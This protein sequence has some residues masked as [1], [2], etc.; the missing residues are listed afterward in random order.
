MERD[1][2]GVWI[3]KEIWLNEDLNWTE[4]LLLVEIDSLSKNGECFASNEHFAK[5]LGVRIRQVQNSLTTLKEKGYISTFVV[6]KEGTLEVE[7]RIITPHAENYMTP[8]AKDCMT[9]CKEVHDPPAT[10]CTTPH[11]I[12]CMYNNTISFTNTITNTKS[13]NNRS[14]SPKKIVQDSIESEFDQFWKL[15]PRK[16][17]KQTARESFIKARKKNKVPYE[18]IEEG[19]YKYVRQLEHQETEVQFITH[20]STWLNQ[21]RWE[22]E[23]ISIT[24]KK[25]KISNFMDLLDEFGGESENG[26][27][28]DTEIIDHHTS[29]IPYA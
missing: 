14:N 1:F 11:A 4:K 24:P 8:H 27:E 16:T 7:K 21:A 22:D 18:I 25:K 9:P 15:Y 29:Y 5:F 6:Y 2:K 10:D 28:R 13:K 17:K 19:L 3:P 12:N 26:H 20:A 23:Y